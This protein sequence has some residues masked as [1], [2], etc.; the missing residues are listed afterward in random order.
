MK[1]RS[2]ILLMVLVPSLALG[3]ISVLISG[4]EMKSVMQDQ[5]KAQLKVA[6]Y[7]GED[8]YEYVNEF[9]ENKGDSSK[10]EDEMNSLI[11]NI[12]NNGGLHVTIFSGEE[13]ITST[14][15][16][17]DG[18]R[19]VGLKAPD[20]VVDLVINQGEDYFTDDVVVGNEH[21]YAYYIP[22]IDDE[23]NQVT[24]I[25]VTAHTK[26]D[27]TDAYRKVLFKIMMGIIMIVIFAVV[28]ENIVIVIMTNAIDRNVNN[29]KLLSD[30]DLNILLKEKDLKRKDEIGE[31][32]QATEHLKESLKTIMTEVN[33][34]ATS[35]L[36]ASEELEQVSEETSTTTEEIEKAVEDV[37]TSAMSQ[38]QSTEEASRQT[39]IMGDEIEN[40]SK[41]VELLQ[42]NAEKMKES[43][44]VA[45]NTLNDLNNIN[46]KSKKEIDAIYRQTNETNEFAQKI[47]EAA[48]VITSIAE[49]TNLLSLNASIE[50][51]RAGETGRGFAVVANQIKSLAEQS[52]HSAKEIGTII[53][54]LIENSNRAVETMNG[55]KNTIEVQNENLNRTKDNFAVVYE[56]INQ[57]TNQIEKITDITKELNVVRITVID[58]ISNLSAISE[59]NAASTEETSAST[60]ELS[61]TVSNIG[62]EISVLRK[63]SDELVNAINIFKL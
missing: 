16:D 8:A 12:Y 38:A 2:K 63:L 55:V 24:G 17:E 46:E 42:L 29:L 28:V 19:V 58:I 61:S 7:A 9:A 44:A 15:K 13:S 48:I 23:S 60:E 49:E 21:Y 36:T 11:D 31:I 14:I 34:T 47:E 3:L 32:V 4:S 5:I 25:F 41:A 30:G 35:L 62:K 53:H 39:V 57:S 50:A 1:L 59:E 22:I 33:Q 51:A 18:N 37:A 6:A 26:Q 43:G 45:M 52:A 54:T 10:Q 56:G 20:K 27:E 40:T